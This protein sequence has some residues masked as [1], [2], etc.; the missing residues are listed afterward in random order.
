MNLTEQ[1]F[2][3][4]TIDLARLFG[5]KVCHFRPAQTEKGWRT[6]ITGDAGFPDLVLVRGNRLILAELKA[7][8]GKLTEAQK[9][10]LEALK[11]TGVETY[12]WKPSDFEDI[13]ALLNKPGE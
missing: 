1:A 7:G 10:W 4:Q 6:S 3:Q 11:Q 2:L 12:C 9:E 8:K 5:W 13:V